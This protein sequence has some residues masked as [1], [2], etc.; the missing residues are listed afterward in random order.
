M[1]DP[2]LERAGK[3]AYFIDMEGTRYRIC[4]VLFGKPVP[5]KK[6]VMPLEHYQANHRYIVTAGG[7]ARAYR[8]IKSDQ[9]ALE[10]ARLQQQ[11]N[12]AGFVAMTSRDFGA[13]R[14]T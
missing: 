4:D 13:L 8:F 6:R 3:V 12:G 1:S 2:H 5:C 9:R 11:L 14:P 10:R 7:V